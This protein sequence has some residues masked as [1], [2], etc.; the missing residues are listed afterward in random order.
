MCFLILLFKTQS[1]EKNKADGY[2]Q[3]LFSIK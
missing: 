2:L 1:L 3:G